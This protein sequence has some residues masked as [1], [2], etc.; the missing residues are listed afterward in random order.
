MKLALSILCLMLTV[1]PVL[2]GPAVEDKGPLSPC[3]SPKADTSSET[4]A[5]QSG[6][7]WGVVIATSFSKDDALAQFDRIKQDQGNLLSAYQPIVVETCDL[8]MG[9]D[10][11][12]SVRIGLDSRDDADKLCAKLQAAGGSCIVQKN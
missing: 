3:V 2:A 12:Y 7:A 8:H 6:P 10:P 4:P 1:A 9:T 11:Q 5:D